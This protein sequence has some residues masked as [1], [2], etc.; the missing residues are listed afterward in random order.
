MRVFYSPM[1]DWIKKKPTR[2]IFWVPVSLCVKVRASCLRGFLLASLLSAAAHQTDAGRL[3]ISS[4][5]ACVTL[6]H[7]VPQR[8]GF[9]VCFLFSFF[10]LCHRNHRWMCE[11]ALSCYDTEFL[12][13]GAR[14]SMSERTARGGRGGGG[15]RRALQ[16]ACHPPA[17]PYEHN[18]GNQEKSWVKP[19][20]VTINWK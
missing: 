1:N 16:A 17:T 13:P 11:A 9:V 7:R 12:A 5:H 14:W 19:F 8:S 3:L 15:W 10:S 6:S 20:V 18:L 4:F 2:V